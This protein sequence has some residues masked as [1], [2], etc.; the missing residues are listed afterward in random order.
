MAITPPMRPPEDGSADAERSDVLRHAAPVRTAAFTAIVACAFLLVVA[1]VGLGQLDRSEPGF[2][3]DALGPEE[4]GAPLERTP[5]PGV[6]VRI[7]SEGYT[8]TRWGDSVSLVGEDVGGAEWRRH[9]HGVTRTTDFGA[10]TIIVDGGR[11]EEFFTVTSRQGERTWRWKLA[12]RLV[13]RL[14]RD[15]SVSFLDPTRRRVSEL[16]VDPVRILDGDGRDVTPDGLRWGLENRGSS[17]WVTLELDDRDLPLPYVID[18]AVTYRDAQTATTA[19]ATSLVINVPAGV[20]ANDLLVAHIARTGNAAISTPSGWT[21]AGGTTNGNFIRQETYYR[22]ASGSEPASYTWTWTGSQ[23]AAGGMSAYYGVKGSSPL[24]VVGTADTANNTTTVTAPSLT[25]TVNDALV[26]AFFASNSNSTYS[27]ATGMTERHEVGTA[28]MSIG[29]DDMSQATA[30]A[31]G[32]KTSTASASGRVVGHQVA[33]DVD[34]VPPTVSQSDP[35]SPLAGTV[36]LGG[37]ANDQDSAVAEVQFQRSPAGAGTWT[38]VG[39][40]DTTSPYSVSFVTTAVT[41]GLYDVRAVATDVAGNVESPASRTFTIDTTPPQTT[42]DSN[43]ADPTSSGDADFTFSAS[44]GGSTFQCRLDG[45]SWG[46]CTSPESYAGLADGSHTFDVRASDA[47][48]NTDATPASFT[49]LV[50]SVDPASTTSFPAAAG[51]YDAAGWDSGCTASGLCG[52]YSDG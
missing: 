15:G 33:L 36:P 24:D 28:G 18:P 25:T 17:W 10:E 20:Q 11:T 14:G 2:L 1:V 5:A 3:S 40:A 29:T 12:T 35:G 6:G 41:D 22:V 39:S 27:T 46:A 44:E 34:D 52:T 38:N 47:V 49:W 48:G 23:P 43:P 51:E 8:I 45:G 50:D 16:V 42:I 7:H 19:G 37:T 26:L 13:P 21:V 9:V 32:A 31:T 4:S 30:G